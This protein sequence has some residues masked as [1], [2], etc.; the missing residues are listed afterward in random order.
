[1][2][3]VSQVES[4]SQGMATP[5]IQHQP[6][7]KTVTMPQ[8]KFDDTIRHA[9]ARVAQKVREERDAHWQSQMSNQS[10]PTSPASHSMTHEEVQRIASEAAAAKHQELVQNDFQQR[11]HA[12]TSRIAQEFFGKMQNADKTLYPNLENNLKIADFSKMG[13]VVSIANSMEGT[14]GIINELLEN[15]T[16]IPTISY[17]SQTQPALA[18]AELKK[19]AESIKLNQQAKTAKMPREPLS[20]LESSPIGMDSGSENSMTTADFRKLFKS[21]GRA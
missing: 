18:Q 20:R 19:M 3:Q 8:S 4:S 11:M 15:P 1:M 16:K 12:E 14:E 6:A 21:K 13:D 9:N 7:E 2:E 17:L 10:Q 5:E